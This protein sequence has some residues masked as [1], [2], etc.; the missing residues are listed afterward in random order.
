MGFFGL[1][2][3]SYKETGRSRTAV[4]T[5]ELLPLDLPYTEVSNVRVS[6]DSFVFQ[7]GAPDTPASIVRVQ[8]DPMAIEVQKRSTEVS[9][10][11]DIRR[12]KPK[13]WSMLSDA[14]VYLWSTFSLKANNTASAEQ[15]ISNAL[16]RRRSPS[17][18][19]I[20]A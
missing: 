10:K 7:R 15:K 8:L 18:L 12:T 3:C 9:G 19:R 5:D 17:T 13:S 1:I 11:P 14:K 20:L 16:S 4:L 2:V 6:A